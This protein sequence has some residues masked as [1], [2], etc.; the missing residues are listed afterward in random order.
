VIPA[1]PPHRG[2]PSVG[3]GPQALQILTTEHW[4]LLSARS[5]GTT[6][7]M[8]R[9]SIFVAALSGAVVALAL[10]AQATDFGDGFVAFAL[11]LLPV[12]Y[13]LSVTTVARLGQVNLEDRLGTFPLVA[14]PDGEIHAH[15]QKHLRNR[16]VE[17]DE[18]VG[19][20]EGDAAVHEA[21]QLSGYGLGFLLSDSARAHEACA[22]F[23]GEGRRLGSQANDGELVL[24][25]Y[26]LEHPGGD[27]VVGRVDRGGAHAHEHF[28]RRRGWRRHVVAQRRRSVKRVEGDCFHCGGPF[29]VVSVAD[30]SRG[31][32]E[33]GVAE[34]VEQESGDVAAR[35]CERA[36]PESELL[37]PDPARA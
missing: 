24:D 21:S 8:S 19:Q 34:L 25:P 17:L 1:V 14:E 32:D 6:E 31:P 28:V 10:I 11:V 35:P 15:W 22:R 23:S 13:F 33:A 5:L 18:V 26:L 7:A 36:I 30:G 2:V 9:A 20:L 37:E 3:P 16:V 29:S 12:V 4:S 27:R